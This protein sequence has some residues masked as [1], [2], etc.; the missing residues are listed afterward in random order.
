MLNNYKE[1]TEV[2]TASSTLPVL[3]KLAYIENRPYIDGGVAEAVPYKKAL[4]DGYDKII[5][6]L[7]RPEGY[8]EKKNMLYQ[9][10]YHICYRKYP[11]LINQLCSM[12]TRYNNLLKEIEELQRNGKVF[13][14]RPQKKIKVKRVEQDK[15]KLR[16]LYLLGRNEGSMAIQGMLEYIK[17]K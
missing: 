16:S 6:V 12:S 4:E 10:L 14:I 8:K 5:I 3:S 7:T 11:K 9:F 1:L 17:R 13:V 2:L 15:S